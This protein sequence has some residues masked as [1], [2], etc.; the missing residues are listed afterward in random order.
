MKKKYKT[1]F[2]II[3]LFSLIVI[4]DILFSLQDV[5]PIIKE[6]YNLN[7]QNQLNDYQKLLNTNKL[8]NVN[9]NFII[10]R[11]SY[12][13]IN[14]FW[15]YVTI[16]KGSNFNVIEHNV[17][18]NE[19]GLIG[20]ISKVSKYS[21]QVMLITNPKINIS[22]KIGNSYG[23][24][25]AKNNKLYVKNITENANIKVGDK[26]YTSGLTKVPENIFVGIISKVE[27]DELGL[28][29]ILELDAAVKLHDINYVAVLGDKE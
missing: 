28:E 16:D 21:S 27:K 9:Q 12:R 6:V 29:Q 8:N 10:S 22:V 25:S 24:L 14:D 18:L 4:K 20:T 13:N 1:I 5:T 15:H 17:V 3:L 23:I 11:V 7:V 19:E 2:I 26:V